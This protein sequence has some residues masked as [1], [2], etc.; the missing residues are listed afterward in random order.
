MRVLRFLVGTFSG[1]ILTGICFYV[2]CRIRASGHLSPDYVAS[3]GGMYG[4]MFGLPLGLFLGAV[5]R[6]LA[7]GALIG[8]IAGLILMLFLISYYGISD[9]STAGG[10]IFGSF[11]P[12]GTISGFVISLIL[13]AFEST[14]QSQKD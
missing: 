6:G 14:E 3:I 9:W 13:L 10:V 5:R 4:A 1:P 11:G 7:F 12:A 2:I 8:G